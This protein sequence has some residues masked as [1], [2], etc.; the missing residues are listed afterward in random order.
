M[1][2]PCNDLILRVDAT[3]RQWKKVKTPGMKFRSSSLRNGQK[4]WI[5]V[6]FG[7]CTVRVDQVTSHEKFLK[8][9]GLT[10]HDIQYEEGWLDFLKLY[11]KRRWQDHK[12]SLEQ[13]RERVTTP[14]FTRPTAQCSFGFEFSD[15]REISGQW[16]DALESLRLACGQCLHE[17]TFPL[18]ELTA[19]EWEIV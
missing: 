3:A 6:D 19:Q 2:D 18:P 5:T 13:A 8:R 14:L 12:R 16:V 1:Y 4:S 17:V 10:E 15:Q 7:E 9:D 11:K